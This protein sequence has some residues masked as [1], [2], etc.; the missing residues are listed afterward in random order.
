[1]LINFKKKIQLSRKYRTISPL[2]TMSFSN[3]NKAH[4]ILSW[5]LYPKDMIR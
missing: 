5:V 3:G 4:P 1:M 2:S